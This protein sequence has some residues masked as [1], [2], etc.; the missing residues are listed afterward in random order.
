VSAG[1]QPCGASP[2]GK[3][4]N[5]PEALRLLSEQ[6]VKILEHFTLLSNDTL[7]QLN[8]HGAVA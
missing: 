6:G 8:E 2:V 5:S 3:P 7:A 4:S 1:V